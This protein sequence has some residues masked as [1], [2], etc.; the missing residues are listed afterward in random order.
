MVID[1]RALRGGMG[2]GA[3]VGVW[4]TNGNTDGVAVGDNVR[5]GDDDN[6][7]SGLI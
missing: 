6:V 2:V 7:A 1:L 3:L 4:V 5:A